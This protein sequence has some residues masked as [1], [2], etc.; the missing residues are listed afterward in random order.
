MSMLPL[1]VG[2]GSGDMESVLYDPIGIKEQLVG[3]TAIQILTN[4]TLTDGVFN[5]TVSGTGILDEDDLVSDSSLHLATQ[6]SIKAYVDTENLNYLLLSGGTM[7]GVNSTTFFQIQQVDT[8]VVFNVDTVNE[9]VGIGTIPSQKFSVAGISGDEFLFGFDNADVSNA[10]SGPSSKF[11]RRAAEGDDYFELVIDQ[12]RRG[13]FDVY[14][15]GDF[16]FTKQIAGNVAIGSVNGHVTFNRGGTGN[17]GVGIVIPLA[18]FHIKGS[19]D[20]Q[21]L[22]IQAHSTQTANIFEIQDSAGNPFISA[23]GAT[24]GIDYTPGSDTD[25]DLIT[26]NVTGTPKFWW[27]QVTDSFE[28]NKSLTLP[29]GSLKI[30]GYIIEEDTSDNDGLEMA[31]TFHIHASG[32]IS[33]NICIHEGTEPP[34]SV[35]GEGHRI[36]ADIANNLLWQDSA[37]VSTVIFTGDP[38]T[39]ALVID[40]NA[41]P[42]LLVEQSGVHDNTLVVDTTNGRVGIGTASPTHKLNVVGDVYFDNNLSVEGLTVRNGVSLG[43]GDLVSE[44][45]PDVVDAIRIKATASD[46]DVVLGDPTGYFSVWNVVDDTAVFYV[47]N[48]GNT[49][50]AG[51]FTTIGTG[52]FGDLVVDTD[53]LVV[54]KTNNRVGIGI[55]S[56][57]SAFHIKA[58]IAGTVGSHPAGQLIIQSP[59]NSVFANAVI[60]GYESDGD[61]NPD[62]QL[63]YLGSSSSSSSD[64]IY[65]NRRNARLMLGTNGVTRITILGNGNVGIGT[66]SPI[67]KFHVSGDAEPNLFVV[68]AGEDEVRIGDWDT[69]YT[70]FAVSG[71]Q[72]MVGTARVYKEIQITVEG[73]KPGATAPTEA[74]IGNYSVLQFAGVG[75]TDE[76]FTIFHIPNDWAEGT[77]ITVHIHWAPTNANAGNVLWQ[78]TWDATESDN[79]EFISDAGTTVS[80]S[81]ATQSLQDELLESGN[82][83]I[84]GASLTLE[85]TIGIRIFRVPSGPDTYA[86]PASLVFVEFRYTSDKLGLAT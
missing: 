80:I 35:T 10:E 57:Y 48:L 20:N 46:V 31:G 75:S 51:D 34:V 72:T 11:Y 79:N 38:M 77:D 81:D 47:N 86:S 13:H 76:V 14:T 27:N 59:T 23:K 6:Q 5:G 3:L 18:R 22:I 85:D 84:S 67:G 21:Q 68:D 29:G 16:L 49:D 40:I 24:D 2:A 25:T 43:F 61:G 4:K 82:M 15:T 78:M 7:V 56:P 69:N 53:T 30:G 17:V 33:G 71:L 26:V 58:N 44:Q 73:L 64:I 52:I 32:G 1:G 9:R 70:A 74:I 62:Q 50:I 83:T 45:N 39:G 36:W 42:A 60:T 8:T 19:Q 54:N 55:D 12:F 65:L 66:I 37:G 41:L 28:M 63:W